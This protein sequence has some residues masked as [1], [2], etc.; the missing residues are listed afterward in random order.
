MGQKVTIRRKKRTLKS[1]KAKG[2]KV[3]KITKKKKK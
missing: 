2:L 1:G 3:R